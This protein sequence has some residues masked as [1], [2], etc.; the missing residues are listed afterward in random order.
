MIF[1]F[2]DFLRI[3]ASVLKFL[4]KFSHSM[5]PCLIP[6]NDL[7][8]SYSIASGC[9]MQWEHV[10]YSIQTPKPYESALKLR[11][12]V[13]DSIFGVYYRTDVKDG[14]ERGGSCENDLQ[15]S[16]FSLWVDEKIYQKLIRKKETI[17]KFENLIVGKN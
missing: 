5:F 13:I 16:K 9:S 7:H 14:C 8:K 4:H 2:K 1:C 17:K 15:S 3:K 12:T 10:S 6:S 11:S